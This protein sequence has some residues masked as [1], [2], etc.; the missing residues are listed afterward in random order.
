MKQLII[1]LLVGLV[2]W[3]AFVLGYL[4]LGYAPVATAAPPLP[5]E[6]TITHFALQARID[7]EAPKSSPVP[8]TPATL[9]AGAEIYHQNC[10]VC[11]GAAD[12]TTS[13]T[14]KGMFPPPPLLL[15]GK[16]VTDDPVGET[17]WKAANGIRLTGMPAYRGSLSD[18]QL[19]Q[20][21]QLLASAD[22]LTPDVRRRVQSND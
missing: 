18:E 8:A 19:W 20:V 5:L 11:H 2:A 14:A 17:Y 16:G 15:H 1:G 22:K 13:A 9:A 12:G 6:R 3:P 7:R 4:W 21:S 10:Q